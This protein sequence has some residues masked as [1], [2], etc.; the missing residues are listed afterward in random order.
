MSSPI[1][2]PSS[3]AGGWT[4]ELP[5]TVPA[6]LMWPPQ[7]AKLFKYLFGFPGLFFP[8]LA[9]YAAIAVGLWKLL[10]ATGSDLTRLSVGWIALLF[11]CNEVLAVGIYG[12]WHSVFYGRRFQDTQFKYNANW[13]KEQSDLFLFRKPLASN[14]FWSLGSGVPIWT[15]YVVLTLWAQA[16]GI[17]PVPSWALLLFGLVFF[18]AVHFYVG[19]RIL[20]WQ[21]LY[22]L[23]HCLHHANVNPSPWTGLA[24]HP[25][26]HVVYFSGALLLWIIPATPI[27]VLYFVTLV[28]LAPAEGHCGFGKLVVGG[29][30]FAT[31][32]YYHYL[33]HKFFRVNFGDSLLIPVDRLFGTFHDGIRRVSKTK[34]K[35]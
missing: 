19:H 25:I 30:S 3:N 10:E 28:A 2:Q 26:E 11:A 5:L 16:N 9:I 7:P 15:A 17:V 8:W 4:P 12:A 34:D 29:R 1:E 14:I 20:H 6:P 27:H 24:M 22:D 21:P 31:D 18:H 23:V 33:H 35:T 13:P 32:N